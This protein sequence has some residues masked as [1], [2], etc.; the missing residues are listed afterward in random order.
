M[1][2]LL[3]WAMGHLLWIH[4]DLYFDSVT[5]VMYAISCYIGSCYNGSWLYLLTHLPIVPHICISESGQHWFKFWLVTYRAPSHYLN[6][7]CAIVNMTLGNKL[8]WH[9]NLNTKLFIQ[10]N[11][12][13]ILSVKR[14]PF[15]AGG[16]ELRCLWLFACKIELWEPRTI[17]WN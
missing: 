14:R 8:Q 3:G 17:F 13:K 9:F 4:T 15:C 10:E 7:C 11:A 2:H 5:A 1:A 6:Q 12:S 16:D